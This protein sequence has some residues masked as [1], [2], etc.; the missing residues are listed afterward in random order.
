VAGGGRKN[1][2]SALIGA[3]AAG[4]TAEYAARQAGVSER[5]VY[6]RLGEPDFRRRVDE[7]RAEMIGRAVGTLALASQ[8]AVAT[9]VDLQKSGPPSVRLGAARAILELGTR[10]RETEEMERRLA[11]LEA[12]VGQR[13]GPRRGPWAA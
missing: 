7:A 12:L 4:G 3:L 10:L 13:S 6:R 2:D 8:G 11:S 1:A 5:T 9:L